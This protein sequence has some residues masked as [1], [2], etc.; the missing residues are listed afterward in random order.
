MSK[1]VTFFAKNAKKHNQSINI[2]QFFCSNP[3]ALVICEILRGFELFCW[4]NCGG[5][6]AKRQNGQKI[7]KKFFRGAVGGG[8][9]FLDFENF[10]SGHPYMAK[11][12]RKK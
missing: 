3:I 12:V 11:S 9:I 8:K 2:T 7:V 6:D 4:K 5:Y 10:T 1:K